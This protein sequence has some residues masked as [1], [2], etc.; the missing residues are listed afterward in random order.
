MYSLAFKESTPYG[1][2]PEKGIRPEDE[3]DEDEKGEDEEEPQ[4][5]FIVR[6]FDYE[7]D[8]EE[9][10]RAVKSGETKIEEATLINEDKQPA[11]SGKKPPTPAPKAPAKSAKRGTNFKRPGKVPPAGGDPATGSALK[12]PSKPM[13][14]EEGFK[15][16]GGILEQAEKD[17]K[18]SDEDKEEVKKLQQMLAPPKKK[19]RYVETPGE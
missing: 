17:G 10:Y 16:I 7:R 4:K 11:F 19:N 9:E 3:E 13:T 8:F 6:Q 15:E 12:K 18:L 14:K 5:F 1:E 2:D